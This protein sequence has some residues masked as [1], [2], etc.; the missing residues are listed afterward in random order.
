V[1][2]GRGCGFGNLSQVNYRLL[3]EEK[4]VSSIGQLYRQSIWSLCWTIISISLYISCLPAST[5]TASDLLISLPKNFPAT[6][7]ARAALSQTTRNTGRYEMRNPHFK[8]SPNR[9]IYLI[10]DPIAA[11]KDAERCDRRVHLALQHGSG[12]EVHE[13]LLSSP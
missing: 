7:R 11:F 8:L 13:L 12:S 1:L 10:D 3:G 9:A 6:V 2:K 4:E 5:L